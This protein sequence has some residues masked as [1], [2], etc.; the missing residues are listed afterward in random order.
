MPNRLGPRRHLPGRQIPGQNRERAPRDGLAA[1]PGHQP[2]AAA[3]PRQ[4]R[5][6]QPPPRPRPATDATAAS[7]RMSD[8]A[9]SLDC[10]P[11]TR[12]RP[13]SRAVPMALDSVGGKVVCS[14]HGVPR[15]LDPY[16]TPTG[17]PCVLDSSHRSH[18]YY[19]QLW[20]DHL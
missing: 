6:R 9:G 8:F 13:R 15:T 19:N 17:S 11:T 7:D 2:A 14:R 20:A 12:E 5:R 16:A 10:R 18:T 3:R 4:H 1:Q